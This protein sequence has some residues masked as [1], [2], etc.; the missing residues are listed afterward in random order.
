MNKMYGFE[1]EVT[2]KYSKEMMRL[3]TDIF[4]WCVSQKCKKC[5]APH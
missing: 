1:G 2:S 5:D 3:F 4:Q